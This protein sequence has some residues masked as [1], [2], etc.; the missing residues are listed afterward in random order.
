M[1]ILT[2]A[3][4][5]TTNIY[6]SDPKHLIWVDRY[7]PNSLKELCG[8][9][10]SI[11][12][13]K[14][15]TNFKTGFKCKANGKYPAVLISGPPGIGK[16]TAAHLVGKDE[17]YD[18]KEFN[19]S[20]VRN[21]KTLDLAIK[22]ATG[23]MSITSF[24]NS[25]ATNVAAVTASSLSKDKEKSE[26]SHTDRTLII[27]DEVDGMSTG[28][29]G[30]TQELI[31]IIKKSKVPIIC[32]CNDNKSQK[33]KSFTNLCQEIKFQ[34]ENLKIS[35]NVV[36]AIIKGTNTDIR[37]VMNLLSCWKL[38]ENSIDF[39]QGKQ[40][41]KNS[42][43]DIVLNVWDAS[44]KLFNP[45]TW[46]P[47]N[48]ISLNEKLGL[49]FHDPDLAP[50]MIQEN[51]IT[52]PCEV[53]SK[54]FVYKNMNR[55]VDP[56]LIKE[57]AVIGCLSKAADFISKGDLIS[58]MIHGS[59]QQW[60]LM[61]FHGMVS[62][63]IPSYYSCGRGQ[64]HFPSWLGQNSKAMRNKRALSKIQSKLRLK[65]NANK[66]EILMDY[67]PA[68]LTK[69]YHP[70][71]GDN[72]I[73]C[74]DEYGLTKEDWET[75]IELGMGSKFEAAMKKI[76]S[77]TKT[78]LTKSR[79]SS[80]VDGIS[81]MPVT[82]WDVNKVNYWLSS[83]GYS[84][85]ESQIKEQDIS[86]EILVH[87]DHEAL[88]DLGVRSVGQRVTILKA[89]YNLKIQHNIPVETGEYVP[90][91]LLLSS[92]SSIE[93]QR[94]STDVS[95]LREELT[96]IWKMAKENKP[97]THIHLSSSNNNNESPHLNAN[98]GLNTGRFRVSLED[99]CYKVLPSALKK[100]KVHDD[101]RKYAL[102]I[103]F[104]S[105]DNP[106]ERCLS[107]DEKP[108]LLFQKLKEANQNPVFML[109]NIK[110]IKSPVATAEEILNSLKANKSKRLEGDCTAV[111]IYPYVPELDDELNVVVGDIFKIR[112]KSGGWCYCEKNG[113]YG[114]VPANFLLETNVNGGDIMD[115]DNPYV[116]RGI[117]LIDYQ[118]NTDDELSMNK[119]DTLRIYKKQDY[120]YY[121]E[122]NDDRGWVPSWY[123][124]IEKDLIDYEHEIPWPYSSSNNSKRL[125]PINISAQKKFGNPPI[126][127]NIPT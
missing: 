70:L 49:Y 10:T 88:K 90:P 14:T 42:E 15:E 92:S 97:R 114:W 28:D 113:Q 33:M 65:C 79:V 60:S 48:N 109:K 104:G 37:Q 51:Y 63:V 111:A 106:V 22:I 64:Y 34:R 126:L 35:G 116:G 119:D 83:L 3:L 73:D 36:D 25:N 4:S 57:L 18:I 30:G 41:I 125:I 26:P 39:D 82:S 32:I 122:L 102:F 89:I 112:S 11:G 53:A 68:L 75:I 59:Q 5:V 12:A 74:L 118:R 40:L 46:L 121:C 31:Q 9:K 110:E 94:L 62:T 76:N 84:A 1:L 29:R 105:Q 95:K 55:N 45:I 20:D 47:N 80:S 98:V 56:K 61:P 23:N 69:L 117:A 43:K 107:Y 100:Y 16:T 6:L 86:G 21:K 120:W 50:L 8:N 38:S 127:M 72:V 52:K 85:Y 123:V 78:N 7:R 108:L 99:P 58:G 93:L 24:Y 17:G 124:K 77:K 81:S 67:I 91:Y 103:C 87:L 71:I 66:D 115:D 27:M 13:L 2:I 101:W 54:E 19:A 96:P 44:A